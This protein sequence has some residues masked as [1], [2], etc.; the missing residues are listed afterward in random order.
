MWLISHFSPTTHLFSKATARQQYA[1]KAGTTKGVLNTLT[2]MI[3]HRLLG[4]LRSTVLSKN[5][6]AW[7]T[8]RKDLSSLILSIYHDKK[9]R[10][11]TEGGEEGDVNS[12][13]IFMPLWV[14]HLHWP[15]LMSA[16]CG[17]SP[18]R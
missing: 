18:T 6:S 14:F 2:S 16:R 15:A 11:A 1:K 10:R 5:R 3:A 9:T 17:I 8:Q 7:I 4:K 12:H 13:F